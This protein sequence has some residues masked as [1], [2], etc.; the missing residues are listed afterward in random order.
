MRHTNNNISWKWEAKNIA[1]LA[2][3]KAMFTKLPV[4]AH[5]NPAKQA[6][7]KMDTLNN[8]IATKSFLELEDCIGPIAF[9]SLKFLTQSTII[10]FTRR[11]LLI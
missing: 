2:K 11:H 8:I 10:Q 6:I 3:L 7:L 9:M 4:L 1:V 5:I